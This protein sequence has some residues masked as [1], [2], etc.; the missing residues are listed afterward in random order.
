MLSY[1][2]VISTATQAVR[3]VMPAPARR[4]C[5]YPPPPPRGS[6]EEY[7]RFIPDT[8]S[9]RMIWRAC[10]GAFLAGCGYM[11]Y[12][13]VQENYTAGG[14]QAAASDVTSVP[15]YRGN[16]VVYLDLGIEQG[17]QAGTEPLGRIVMQL[18]KDA[19]PRT[20][21]NFHKF[22]IG[23]ASEGRSYRG[24]PVHGIVRDNY[25][26]LGS[27]GDPAVNL[28]ASGAHFPD[29]N[30]KLRHMGPGVLSSAS[31]VRGQNGS[32]FFITLTKMP[33][34][35]KRYVPFG[36]VLAGM[37]VLW[38]VEQLGSM[39]GNP[40]ARVVVMDAGEL[41]LPAG[42]AKAAPPPPTGSSSSK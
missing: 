30:F 8:H 27:M 20:V 33:S 15:L 10:L 26:V 39:N 36:N 34:L 6:P 2:P 42:M 3:R 24:S 31:K 19:V 21:E 37:D 25:I 32:Q 17:E 40:S 22:F 14:R 1:R 41:R 23:A 5:S 9:Q 4:M 12:R 35:D 11:G 38:K 7:E 29:E 13:F 18:R 28:D 16:P